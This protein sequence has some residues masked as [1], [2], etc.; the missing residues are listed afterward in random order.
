[1]CEFVKLNIIEKYSHWKVA[2]LLVKFTNLSFSFRQIATLILFSMTKATIFGLEAILSNKQ[3][4]FIDMDKKEK[5]RIWT[6]IYKDLCALGVPLK[7]YKYLRETWWINLKNGS[8]SRFMGQSKSKPKHTKIDEII[9]K[10]LGPDVLT[11]LTFHRRG[12]EVIIYY[13]FFYE[14]LLLYLGKDDKCYEYAKI[15]KRVWF[16]RIVYPKTWLL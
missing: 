2:L 4:L 8:I 7:D 12:K 6:E 15:S 1:L 14:F 11:D 10:I 3:V 5:R 13:N 16:F 9:H